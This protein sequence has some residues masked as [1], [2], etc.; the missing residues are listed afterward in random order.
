VGPKRPGDQPFLVANPGKY[1][2]MSGF[3]YTYSLRDIINS[4]WEHFKNGI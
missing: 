2:R 4:S 1:E 3:R